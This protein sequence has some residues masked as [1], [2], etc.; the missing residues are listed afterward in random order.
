MN[1]LPKITAKMVVGVVGLGVSGRSAVAFALSRGAEVLVSESRPAERLL[2]EDG[3]LLASP[4]VHWEAG[5]HSLEFLGRADLLLLGPGVDPRLPLFEALRQKGVPVCG[6][7]AVVAAELQVPLVAV[8]GTNGKTTV[9]T[10]IGELLV[11]AGKRP[12][13]GGNIGTPL[14]E[15]LRDPGDVELVVAEVSSFQLEAAGRF[16][17]E[18]AVLLNVTPDHL[19]RHGHLAGYIEA[20]RR[21]FAGH[22]AG[23]VAIL[24]GD[25]PICREIAEGLAPPA[26]L[27]GG[28]ADC[29]ARVEPHRVTL[30]RGEEVEIYP[31]A[32]TSLEGLPGSANAAAAILA[33][34]ALGAPATAVLAGLRRFRPLPHRLEWVAEVAGVA[35]YNDSKAT[36]SGAVLAA[37]SRFPG[38]VVLI[39][40]GRDKGDDYRLLRPAVAEKV[41][42]LILIGEAA[43][44]LAAALADLVGT[45]RA[46]S[47]AEAV[48]LAAV[49]ARP[50]DVV[51]LSPSCAS[52]DMFASYRHRGEEFRRVVLDLAGMALVGVRG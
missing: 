32:G 19:D 26:E 43:G 5:G 52:F 25:D 8:T 34:R 46:G 47:M 1:E 18:V 31:L 40:G 28:G 48:A 22:G 10:L 7:L 38:R 17:P 41:A 16:A 27:F 30:R 14:Y 21:I 44:Q 36:N 50:G 15:Y 35:Y 3:A 6:E 33:A 51:L 42:E 37:L 11:A 39:A 20:K 13:V 23:R 45:H 12:F 2:A 9:T 29:V 4:G 24:N 49:L